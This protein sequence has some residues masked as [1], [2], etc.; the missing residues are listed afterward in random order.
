MFSGIYIIN[1]SSAELAKGAVTIIIVSSLISDK[2]K[3]ML[4]MLRT[5]QD[6][7]N[8]LSP[9]DLE[10]INTGGKQNPQRDVD[11]RDSGYV[12]DFSPPSATS[13]TLRQF[14]FDSEIDEYGVELEEGIEGIDLHDDVFPDESERNAN[15][16]EFDDI[17]NTD[18]EV[19]ELFS[20]SGELGSFNSFSQP[21]EISNLRPGAPAPTPDELHDEQ[22]NN[23]AD[24]M[25]GESNEFT[26]YT[27]SHSFHHTPWNINRHCRRHVFRPISRSVGTQTPS[28]HSQ[29]IDEAIEMCGGARFQPCRLARGKCNTYFV[30]DKV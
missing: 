26:D 10:I 2:M 19:E 9:S 27:I 20:D 29:I 21:I 6:E 11:V 28:P 22:D 24:L 14:R 5:K 30:V 1:L 18:K 3:N 4:Q 12:T 25:N 17:D 8:R 7:D 13:T 23:G 16:S 15:N